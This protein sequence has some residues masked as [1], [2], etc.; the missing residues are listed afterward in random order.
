[1]DHAEPRENIGD[2]IIRRMSSYGDEEKER[3]EVV[4]TL[5]QRLAPSP[6]EMVEL[7]AAPGD[8]AIAFARLG[9]AV[10]AVDLGEASDEWGQQSHGTMEAGFAEAGVDLLIWDLE[11]IPYPTD[12]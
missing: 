8:Q 5:I 11:K 6:A 4:R 7:G 10:T 3:H 2:D 9:Y 12:C 1:V